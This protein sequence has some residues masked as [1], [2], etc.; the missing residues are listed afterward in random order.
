M[1]APGNYKVIFESGSTFVEGVFYDTN[2]DGVASPIDALLVIN[3]LNIRSGNASAEGESS[4]AV[5]PLTMAD[6][7]SELLRRKSSR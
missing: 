5:T 1:L 4:A 3:A 7:D 6:F 2:F